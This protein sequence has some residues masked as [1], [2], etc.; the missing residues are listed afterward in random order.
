MGQWIKPWGIS[1]NPEHK[2]GYIHGHREMQPSTLMNTLEGSKQDI[3]GEV[4]KSKDVTV[5]RQHWVNS[6]KRCKT[7]ME[8]FCYR[9]NCASAFTTETLTLRWWLGAAAPLKIIRVKLG[10]KW[11]TW[12]N[13]IETLQGYCQGERARCWRGWK[14]GESAV[15][16]PERKEGR[17][18]LWL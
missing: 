3:I 16:E 8:F 6:E 14:Q 2:E 7:L 1:F 12:W 5:I 10:H 15:C 9:W 4:T 11:G 13:K 18:T 17:K